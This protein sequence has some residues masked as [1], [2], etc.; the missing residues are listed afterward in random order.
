MALSP[1]TRLGA[2]EIVAPLG[3]GGMGKV[4]RARDTRLGR[5]VA[6][7]ILPPELTAT[8][9]ARASFEREARAISHLNHPNI[10][11]LHDVGRDGETDYLVM[12]L[13]SGG[14]LRDRMAR[15][16]LPLEQ[17]I[18]LGSEI[19]DAL[20]GAHAR[21]IVH[22]H[23]KPSN[24]LLTEQGQAKVTDF[25][26]AAPAPA[27]ESVAYTSPE[28]ARDDEVDARS[29]VFSLGALLYE[30]ASGHHAFEGSSAA[31]IREAILNRTPAAAS[32][33]REGVPAE[34]DRI[35][36]KALEKD[37]EL[38]Y[39]T[40][41]EVRS[42]LRRLRQDFESS[43]VLGAV[44]TTRSR[45]G[46]DT[47][48]T[49]PP[50][51][52][53]RR[54][55][56]RIAWGAA[57][58]VALSGAFLIATRLSR[59]GPSLETARLSIEAPAT[60]YTMGSPRISPDGQYV[61]FTARDSGDVSQIWLVPMDGT[62][63]RSLP[64]TDRAGTPFWSPDS[65]FI[66]F[67]VG[68]KLKKIEVAGGQSITI[69]DSIPPGAGFGHV[70]SW[71]PSGTILL[72]GWTIWA[73]SASGGQLTQVT[74]PDR[75]RGEIDA[76][77][78]WPQF[79]P[80]GKHF[81]Y[82]AGIEAKPESTA[83]RLG[84]LGSKESKILAIGEFS[85][86][87]YI[88]PGYVLYLR[89]RTLLVQAFEPKRLRLA[90]DA[91]AV[92]DDVLRAD[93]AGGADFSASA[94]GTLVYRDVDARPKEQLV[95]IDRTG[96]EIGSVGQASH[97]W[98]GIAMSPD[99]NR[100]AIPVQA[101]GERNPDIWIIDVARDV[102]T[103]FTSDPGHEFWPIWSPDGTTVFFCF[104]THNAGIRVAMKSASGIG[105][106]RELTMPQG[107]AY[108]QGVTSDGRFLLASLN[109]PGSKADIVKVSLDASPRTTPL[110][111]SAG[112]GTPGVGIFSLSRDG[113]WIAYISSE[114]GRDEVYV[115]DFPKITGKWRISE[116]GARL[117]RWSAD[118]RE[119]FF[120]T[121]E[122]VL[123]SAAVSTVPTFHVSRPVRMFEP[124]GG[125]GDYAPSTDGK[126][127]L[128]I[129]DARGERLPPTKVVVNWPATLRRR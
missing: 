120:V 70:G 6:I 5:D 49:L 101:P 107:D 117:P 123:M 113:K 30:M 35:L 127:F 25:G 24:I 14:N 46:A 67:A 50:S 109:L 44:G 39:Q 80:D 60:L 119:L 77:P 95:W 29:D 74:W 81:L 32:M 27:I 99:E 33:L 63:A 118:G 115:V 38:R 47:A 3:A 84:L 90:G 93:P 82:T 69:C 105:E 64:G 43:R 2:Y 104:A 42:D 61:A 23:L 83:L 91:V 92:V 87:E 22:R 128:A 11:K 75:S 78:A 16:A 129:V 57:A 40:A 100:V 111:I 26:L 79:L 15:K 48:F 18:S 36:G 21:G 94:T 59:R 65:R 45:V 66:G 86:V 52:I 58:V 122:G 34:L 19:A 55:L 4:Y 68:R 85:R 7:K 1:G 125:T 51:M 20:E 116:N 31:V 102:A 76:A 98:M 88:A 126:R 89:G 97:Y 56:L 8:P 124:P 53:A 103:R 71:G 72:C 106:A 17:V 41:G 37:R 121:P 73:V 114:S 10:C 28:Q 110:G 12:E 96:R 62:G 54:R 108:P 112:A 9:E 13:V